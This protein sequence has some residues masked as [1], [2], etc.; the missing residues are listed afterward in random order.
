MGA[1]V[2]ACAAF[3]AMALPALANPRLVV[4]VNSLKV[5]E[6][7][8]IFQKWYP[9]SLTKLMT[10]YTTFRAIKSGQLT[11]ES[12]V[13]M[14]KNAASEPPSKMFYKPGQAMTL[15]SALKMMLVKSANDVAVAIAETVGGS[16]QAFIDR[17][18]AE[19]RR[20]GMTS[21]H[22][23]NANGLPGQGQYTTARDLAV[24]A[25][26][27]KREFPEYSAYFSLEGFTTGKKDY[28]NYNM[29][30]GRFEG[31]DGMKT[32]FICASGFNQVSSATRA[33]RSV[34][35][36]VLG[37]DSLGARADESARL[38]QMA[39]TTNNAGKPSLVQ[40]APYGETRDLVADVSKEICSKQ[41]AK[42][43]SEGRDEAGRQKL[44]SPY[45][46]ELNRPLKLTF[47]GLMP[48]SSDKSAKVAK[49]ATGQG[50]VA[51]IP[52]PVPRPSL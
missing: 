5:Y 41:A 22:F 19:A 8:D 39:L 32:G 36:V 33:G 18:N 2:V 40:I 20:I 9:A 24:L 26:T 15:D 23:I 38:L 47:A 12:P 11:L 35:S 45:I 16:E 17:M 44:L 25:I 50:D 14:T 4:D 1:L 46:R 31:A 49:D 51:N 42:V 21:S 13:I 6:H 28:A 52:I 27:L 34:V 29:L 43:R 3:S 7:Q 48:G 30:I 37:E 10:A